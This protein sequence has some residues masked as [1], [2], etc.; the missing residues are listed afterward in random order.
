MDWWKYLWFSICLYQSMSTLLVILWTW[1]DA[2]D[3]QIQISKESQ[4]KNVFLALT[5]SGNSSGEVSNV[6]LS[7]WLML[8]HG[9]WYVYSILRQVP[10]FL[11]RICPMANVFFRAA[12]SHSTVAPERKHFNNSIPVPLFSVPL[13]S[14]HHQQWCHEHQHHRDK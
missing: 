12:P 10:S 6:H 7:T 9:N 8:P 2:N 1:L 13:L 4:R 14:P 3:Y 5:F 11:H